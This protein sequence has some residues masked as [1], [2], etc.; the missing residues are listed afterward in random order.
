[1]PPIIYRRPNSLVGMRTAL[2]VHGPNLNL[3][4]TREPEIYGTTT[5]IELDKQCRIWGAEIGMAVRSF[6]SNHEGEIIDRIH[7]ARSEP[8]AGIV[9][10]PGALGHYSYALHDAITSVALP[11]VE[12]H[13]S[14]TDSR[15]DWRKISVIRAACV[16]TFIGEGIEGYR[17]ALRE[18]RKRV[19]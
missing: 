6:Q 19:D 5:L 18:L 2:V 17:S 12:V 13:I 1:L 11:T 16:A 4:G 15:E 8:T 3:L 7:Q 14:D 9:I 10:N